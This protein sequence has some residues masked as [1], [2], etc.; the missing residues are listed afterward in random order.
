MSNKRE[1]FIKH[2]FNNFV[3]FL[4]AK[5]DENFLVD[6]GKFNKSKRNR[7]M[8]PWITSG[9]IASVKLISIANG[10]NLVLRKINLEMNPCIHITRSSS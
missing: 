10:K 3:G 2:N 5:I 8:N 1:R 7:L 9:I 6:E 4:H